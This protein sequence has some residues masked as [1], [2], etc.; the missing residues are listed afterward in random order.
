MMFMAVQQN[1]PLID[2]L[3]AVRGSYRVNVSM[4]AVTWFKVGGPA[5]VVFRPADEADLIA[6]LQQ[7]PTDVD[8]TLIGAGS[9]LLI[10]DGGI[11]GVVI[12]MGREMA[13][14]RIEG[15][16]V[17]AAGM[18][19]D[20]NIARTAAD[21]GLT[22][23]EFLR[24]IPGSIGASLRTNAGAYGREIKDVLI[25][26]R[27][28][29]NAGNVHEAAAADLK[30]DY[31]HSDFP[32]DWIITEVS[33]RAEKGEAA[34]I[35][36]RMAAITDA[37][38][39]TQPVRAR[40]GGSTFKNPAGHRAWELIDAAGCRGLTRGGAQVSEQHC[41]FLIN[42]GDA[43]ARDLEELGEE[44]RRQVKANSGIDL[45]WEIKRIGEFDNQ[46]IGTVQE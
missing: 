18:A 42:L 13:K 29:D 22:G 38:E 10:R 45:E 35:A 30:L 9:N 14:V 46:V 25:A 41:N 24:G 16:D 28:V 36:A 40:T 6:F 26:I 1:N 17:F 7:R 12:R 19:M 44:V 27:A 11:S 31:R 5:E 33:L 21:G 32:D 20:V 4:A 2:R 39:E 34:D 23:L 37:R 8:V 3:P 15:D 43:T